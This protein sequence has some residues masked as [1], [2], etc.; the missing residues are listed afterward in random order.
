MCFMMIDMNMDTNVW[1]HGE[2]HDVVMNHDK[3][4]D[5]DV[6]DVCLESTEHG[7]KHVAP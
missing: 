3:C 5:V 1:H 2:S 7:H 6:C 4:C